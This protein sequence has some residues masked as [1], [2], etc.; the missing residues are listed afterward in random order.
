M[1]C[2]LSRIYAAFILIMGVVSTPSLAQGPPN[3]QQGPPPIP[4]EV[5]I[6]KMFAELSAELSLTE[7]QQTRIHALYVEHFKELKELRKS[8]EEQRS[9]GQRKKMEALRG[10]FEKEVQA[11]FSKEQRELFVAFQEKRREGRP[12][13]KGPGK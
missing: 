1:K 13:R 3:A 9:S 7:E 10:D 12:G 6:E 2:Y 11:D 5:Q 8:E 4:N